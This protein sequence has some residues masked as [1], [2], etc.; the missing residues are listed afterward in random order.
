VKKRPMVELKSIE[1][2]NGM[3]NLFSGL[4]EFGLGQLSSDLEVYENK[5]DT[6]NKDGSA[7]DVV[8]EFSE[9][10]ILFDK[11]MTCP[12]CDQTIKARTI[13]TGRV[14]LISADT[15][16]RPKYQDVDSLKYDAI[17][18][19]KCGYAAL[20]RFFS[21]MTSGQAKLVKEKIS[22]NFRG[23]NQ[24]MEIYSYDDAIARHKLALVNA[25]VKNSKLSERA[26]ICLK[27]GWLYRGKRENLPKDTPDYAQVVKQLEKEESAFIEKAYKGFKD[28]FAKE[29]FPM[30]GMDEV[31][32]TYLVA[33]LA[34]RSGEFDDA[35]RWISRVLVSRNA[36]ERI[37]DKAR[38]IKELIRES[39][40]E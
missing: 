36:N 32:C 8:P 9:A 1:G 2:G 7:E 19:P 33:D 27:T 37:K 20:R 34:R 39:K 24:E 28:A 38:D 6:P 25:V 11:T 5:D 15:D 22:T 31:T 26:Y 3:S 29:S 21:Y 35:S 18:C 10:D 40:S 17:V 23:I 30:C 14:K 12:V 16:L 13:K 4:E